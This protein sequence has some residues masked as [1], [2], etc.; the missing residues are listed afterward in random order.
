MLSDLR[1]IFST[2]RCYTE[3]NSTYEVP[4]RNSTPTTSSTQIGVLLRLVP[5]KELIQEITLEEVEMQ[6]SDR[7][8]SNRDSIK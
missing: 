4:T 8:H 3:C 2:S 5:I 7:I 1:S 6:K